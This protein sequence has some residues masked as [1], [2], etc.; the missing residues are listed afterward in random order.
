MKLMG[1]DLGA[2]KVSWSVFVDG[3]LETAGA[4]EFKPRSTRALELVHLVEALPWD[5]VFDASK[6][7]IEEPPVGR[8]VRASLLLA[9]TAGALAYAIQNDSPAANVHLVE[10]MSWKKAITGSG[11]AKKEEIAAWLEQSHE[12]W[13]RDF[14][15]YERPKA[16]TTVQQDV[17]DAVCIGLYGVELHR[18]TEEFAQ[19]TAS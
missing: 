5:H 1:I 11:S 19:G 18:R 13:F 10:N 3:E 8:S 4:Y 6:V 16:G 17:V 15:L 12:S 2:R 9:Q 14:C 7:F